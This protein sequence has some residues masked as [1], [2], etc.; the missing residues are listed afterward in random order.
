MLQVPP[1]KIRLATFPTPIHSW[2]PTGLP[3]N[4]QMLI[5]RDDLSG[6]QLSGNKVGQSAD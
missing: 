3:E 4:V 1:R 6:M 2:H 5:K